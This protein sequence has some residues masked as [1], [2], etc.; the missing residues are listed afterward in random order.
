[1]RAKMMNVKNWF[2]SKKEYIKEFLERYFLAATVF[3][4]IVHILS[5][6]RALKTGKVWKLVDK[7]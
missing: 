7:E 3:V 4:W 5:V 1:M 2:I 6:I